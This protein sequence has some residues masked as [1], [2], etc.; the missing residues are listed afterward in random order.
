MA[1]MNKC[2]QADVDKVVQNTSFSGHC[3][4][5]RSEFSFP[6]VERALWPSLAPLSG[7]TLPS[8]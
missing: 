7:L 5:D 3:A 8:L 1:L 4:K 2:G 6:R